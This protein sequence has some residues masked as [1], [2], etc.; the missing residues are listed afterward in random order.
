MTQ[1]YVS[2]SVKYFNI[3]YYISR[4]VFVYVDSSG[5]AYPKRYAVNQYLGR[6]ILCYITAVLTL[7]KKIIK[8]SYLQLKLRYRNF[9]CV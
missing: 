3:L 9:F 7:E 6:Y 1:K 5:T 4:F 8:F 2:F